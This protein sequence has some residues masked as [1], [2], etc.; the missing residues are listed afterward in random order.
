MRTQERPSSARSHLLVAVINLLRRPGTKEPAQPDHE[1]SGCAPPTNEIPIPYE[2]PSRS[3]QRIPFGPPKEGWDEWERK[4][5]DL[6]DYD[7]L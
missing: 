2:P 5:F 6:G 3:G 1:T 4:R 7:L